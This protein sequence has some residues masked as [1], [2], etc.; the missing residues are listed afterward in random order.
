MCLH[1]ARRD[2]ELQSIE[3]KL[4]MQHCGVDS[5]GDGAPLDDP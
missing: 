2:T 5:D 1:S 4:K 3:D